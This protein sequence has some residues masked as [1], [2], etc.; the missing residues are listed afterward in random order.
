MSGRTD[1]RDS[2]EEVRRVSGIPQVPSQDLEAQEPVSRAGLEVVGNVRP[3]RLRHREEPMVEREEPVE[4]RV[5]VEEAQETQEERAREAIRMQSPER[6]GHS[7]SSV[8]ESSMGRMAE[9][10]RRGA[11][12]GQ[13]QEVSLE[14]GLEVGR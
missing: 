10:C 11:L 5:E 6:A 13:L 8:K 12:R 2:Q 1:S 7:S 4:G 9:P 14:V 3:L